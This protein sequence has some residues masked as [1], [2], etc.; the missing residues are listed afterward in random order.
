MFLDGQFYSYIAHK[1]LSIGEKNK[2]T[3]KNNE[4][5]FNDIVHPCRYC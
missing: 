3:K 1:P 5:D 4:G 2:Q